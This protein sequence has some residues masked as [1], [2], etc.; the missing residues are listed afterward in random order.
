MQRTLIVVLALIALTSALSLVRASKTGRISSRGWTFQRDES[1]VGF[2]FIAIIDF[3]IL[4]ASL[5][6]ALRALGLIGDLPT[7]LTLPS[8]SR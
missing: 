6:L 3:G 7:S 2:W 8:G 4:V 1:P 5:G